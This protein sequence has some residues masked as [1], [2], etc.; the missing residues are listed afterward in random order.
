MLAFITVVSSALALATSVAADFV[1]AGS[2]AHFFSSQ[3]SSLVFAPQF[4][5]S[6]ASLVASLAGDGSPDDITALYAIHGSG[7]P[8]QIAYGDFCITA[9]GVVPE[10]ATQTLYVAECDSTDPAQLWTLNADPQTVSNAD[11]N[12]ITLGRAAK[13]VSVVLDFCND[14][15]EHLQLW[16]PKPISA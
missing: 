16:D 5:A 14:I 13:G 8:T 11:G 2:A 3:N 12:C 15:L 1:P 6:G 9:K 10:S 4:A 7:V